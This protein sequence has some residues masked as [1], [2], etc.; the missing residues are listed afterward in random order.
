MLT[1]FDLIVVDTWDIVSYRHSA[2]DIHDNS[3]IHVIEQ[4]EAGFWSPHA[5]AQ[6]FFDVVR[7]SDRIIYP[8]VCSDLI[9]QVLTFPSNIGLHQHRNVPRGPIHGAFSAGLP[10]DC[11]YDFFDPCRQHGL[12]KHL[13]LFCSYNVSLSHILACIVSSSRFSVTKVNLF[14]PSDLVYDFW[15]EFRVLRFIRYNFLLTLTL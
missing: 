14:L 12:C 7:G 15:C 9:I 11:L 4:V 8:N 13:L 2:T 5:T 1:T 10:Y 6:R 3:S